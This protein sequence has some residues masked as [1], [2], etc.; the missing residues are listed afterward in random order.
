MANSL[1][2]LALLVLCGTVAPAV[3]QSPSASRSSVPSSSRST[4]ASRSISPSASAS[5]SS[6][7]SPSPS[8]PLV[9]SSPT[10][11]ANSA[12]DMLF[13]YQAW[14][15]YQGFWLEVQAAF[16]VVG[17]K[18]LTQSETTDRFTLIANTYATPDF[19]LVFPLA[20]INSTGRQA[21]VDALV[22]QTLP[23]PGVTTGN[24]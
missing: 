18:N 10:T 1:L 16:A 22:G 20:G 13:A 8:P 23:V 7:P 21:L 3:S 14:Q 19:H 9:G 2:L 11:I 6:S 24:G 17:D 4:S 5:S 15:V 12:A